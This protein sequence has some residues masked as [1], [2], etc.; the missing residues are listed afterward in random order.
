MASLILLASCPLVKPFLKGIRSVCGYF[1]T[2][3]F[4]SFKRTG[5]LE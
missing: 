1:F 2:S 5:S 4:S 3:S